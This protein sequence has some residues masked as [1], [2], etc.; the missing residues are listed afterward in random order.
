MWNSL[1]LQHKHLKKVLPK[2]WFSLKYCF[3]SLLFFQIACI[4]IMNKTF[5]YKM[6]SFF[7]GLVQLQFQCSA[8]RLKD[9]S[10][11][12]QKHLPILLGGLLRTLGL[13]WQP[14]AGGREPHVSSSASSGAGV[15]SNCLGHGVALWP[16]S[17]NGTCR[18][19]VS[20]GKETCFVWSLDY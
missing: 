4:S 16:R 11:A 14:C 19:G 1:T 3:L 5:R 7:V 12:R 9:W 6:W 20:V 17:G 10:G 18:N 2:S 13:C 8:Q 15:G